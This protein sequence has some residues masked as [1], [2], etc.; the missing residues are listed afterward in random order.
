MYKTGTVLF[1]ALLAAMFSVPSYSANQVPESALDYRAFSALPAFVKPRLSPDGTKIVYVRNVI[2]PEE[3]SLLMTYDLVSGES[4]YLLSSDNEKV[5]INWFRWVN[6]KRLVVS[7]R[8]ESRRGT[9]KVYDT[10]LFAMDYDH[11][12]GKA[13]NLINWR[14]LS[15]LA[16]NMNHVPQ[17]QD[18]VIDWLPDDP[19]H[20]LMAIDVEVAALPS[21]FKVNVNTARATRIEKGKKQIRH[22]ITDQQSNVRVGVSLNY[23]T[24]E[25]QVLLKDNDDWRVLA[26]YNAMTEQGFYPVGFGLDPNLLYYKAYK[27]DYLALYTLDLTTD[28]RTEV[29]Y[30]EGYDVNGSLIYSSLTRDVIG[31]RHHGR[32]YWDKGFEAFQ[33]GLEQALPDTYNSI[34]SFSRDEQSYIVYSESDVMPGGYYIGNRKDGSL[35]FMFDQYPGIQPDTLVPHRLITYKARDGME[36]QGYLSLPNGKGPFPTI[37]HPH[38]GPGARDYDGFDYWTSYFTSKGYAVLRPNFRGSSGYGYSFAQSRIQSWGLQM[39]DDITDAAHWMVEQGYSEENNMC[40]VGASYGG[41]AALMATVKTPDLFNCAVSFAGVSS[42]KHL[43]QHSRRFL[44]TEFVQHQIG[45]ESRDLKARS[46]YYNVEGIKTPILL[47]H[48]EEDRV[49]RVRQSRIMEDELDDE[50]KVFTYVELESGDH[51]LSIQRNRHRMFAEMDAFLEKYL[52]H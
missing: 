27:G 14:R 9:T 49:V 21:V 1:I 42:L 3:M 52:S 19:D 15:R 23:D 44:N 36:I 40:I 17:I 45:D 38:G 50:D 32:H 18:E 33:K 46:P 26:E 41:Y 51:Y 12:E 22:W 48:G 16:S 47:I 11:Q 39:Q 25:R 35:Y 8:Y 6:D 29:F 10:R 7:A 28:E 31:I 20:I 13:L 4:F 5:K 37:I 2:E 24:G 43:V 34:V 30:D